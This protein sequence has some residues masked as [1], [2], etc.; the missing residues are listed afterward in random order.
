MSE[1][2]TAEVR[3]GWGKNSS[4][5][6]V[7]GTLCDE[8]DQLRKALEPFANYTGGLSPCG[9]NYSDFREI[10]ERAVEAGAKAISPLIQAILNRRPMPGNEITEF[11]IARAIAQISLRLAFERAADIA[12]QVEPA[13]DD[14]DYAMGHAKRHGIQIAFAILAEIDQPPYAPGETPA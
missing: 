9:L 11:Q 2:N 10:E 7:I 12:R 1:I 5:G 14:S 13:M 3:Q 8:I 4:A 6:I